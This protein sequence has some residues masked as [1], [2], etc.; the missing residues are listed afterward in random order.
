MSLEIIES[1]NDNLILSKNNKL[2]IAITS[3]V[4]GVILL[5]FAF[6]HK[7]N[8]SIF[9]INNQKIM[10]WIADHRSEQMTQVFDTITHIADPVNIIIFTIILS[11][12]WYIF[13]REKLRP[14]LLTVFVSAAGLTST[15]LKELIKNPRPDSNFMIKPYELDYSF[16]SGH[17]LC[18]AAFIIFLS[19]LMYSRKFS[20]F[21]YLYW[22]LISI[23]VTSLV[24]ISRLY[25]GYHWTTDIIASIGLTLIILCIMIFTDLLINK[26]K[27]DA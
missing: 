23:F 26:Y 19:Y 5:S 21:S 8:L 14:I 4:A 11:I 27:K 9:E 3:L 13:K 17:T 18:T 15:I 1:N 2:I 24:A 6:F 25:L 22:L 12:V 16:P 10:N 7:N 20:A